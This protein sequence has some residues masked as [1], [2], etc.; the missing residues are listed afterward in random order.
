MQSKEEE[1]NR[2]NNLW[3]K[4]KAVILLFL[5]LSLFTFSYL[6]FY[7]SAKHKH[8]THLSVNSEIYHDE[9]FVEWGYTYEY[10][11]DWIQEDSIIHVN[12][13]VL[14]FSNS[15]VSFK[16]T[17]G[18]A[19]AHNTTLWSPEPQNFTLAPGESFADNFTLLWGPVDQRHYLIYHLTALTENS[20]ATVHLWYKYIFE[21]KPVPIDFWIT[22][23]AICGTMFILIVI[24]RRKSS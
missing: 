8:T 17:D 1:K 22:V 4:Q 3:N 7:G 6:T 23:S 16:Y 24:R 21:A 18:W 20:N 19:V 15:S 14:D 5:I 2:D 13:T 12:F 10:A 11:T 9:K